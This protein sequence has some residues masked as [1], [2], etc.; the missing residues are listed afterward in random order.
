MGSLVVVVMVRLHR[1]IRFV[2]P[3]AWGREYWNYMFLVARLFSA[4]C[5]HKHFCALSF[6]IP[7][8]A[9]RR[10]FRRKLREVPVTNDPFQWVW[11]Y[12]NDINTKLGKKTIPLKQAQEEQLGLENT[13][14]T[15][16]FL[17]VLIPSIPVPRPLVPARYRSTSSYSREYVLRRWRSLASALSDVIR[18]S[19]QQASR[20]LGR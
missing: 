2:K 12:K 10:H 1:D 19:R 11:R 16:D 7:C 15:R 14:V 20:R 8:R 4:P 6:F 18:T 9:C 5:V 3:A 13:N 17:S